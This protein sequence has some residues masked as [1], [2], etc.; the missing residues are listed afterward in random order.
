[1]WFVFRALPEKRT[2][3][4]SPR[5]RSERELSNYRRQQLFNQTKPYSSH[6]NWTYSRRKDSKRQPRCAHTCQMCL[7]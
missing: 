6:E 3:S 2:T 4:P 1:M 7:C 5:E